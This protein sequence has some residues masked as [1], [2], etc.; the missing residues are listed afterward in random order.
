VKSEGSSL[1]EAG[2]DG[3]GDGTDNVARSGLGELDLGVSFNRLENSVDKSLAR[4]DV[5]GVVGRGDQERVS[6]KARKTAKQREWVEREERGSN[7]LLAVHHL[8]PY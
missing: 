7:A 5:I 3:L 8:K 2:G 6:K 4:H 1:P